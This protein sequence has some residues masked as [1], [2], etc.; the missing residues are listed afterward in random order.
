M[1]SAAQRAFL[2]AALGL[3]GPL[4][5]RAD[6][7][8]NF[9]GLG[10]VQ[11][12]SIRITGH[13]NHELAWLARADAPVGDFY[14]LLY[15]DRA[16]IETHYPL[17]AT[18]RD[19]V[20]W[21]NR[22]FDAHITRREVYVS[23]KPMMR[24]M[25][26]HIRENGPVSPAD[27]NEA[28]I[29]GGFNTIKASTRALEYLYYEGKLQIA[30]RTAHYHRL[31]DLTE[32]VV[33][34]ALAVKRPR[35]AERDAFFARSALEVLKLATPA[36]WVDRIAHHWLPRGGKAEAR[37][38]LERFLRRQSD[39]DI[40]EMAP[41]LFGLRE[42]KRRVENSRGDSD[43][44]RV[45]APLENLLFHRRRFQE[46]FGIPYKFEAYTPVHARRFYYALP[47]LHRDEIIGLLDAGKRGGDWHIVAIELHKPVSRELLRQA[48]H[49]LAGLAGAE[50]ITTARGL[51]RAIAVS[52]KGKIDD[53]ALYR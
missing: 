20:P 48:I 24:R 43:I 3:S 39:E 28:R 21:L 23:L 52:L 1:D 7:K 15:R 44:V 47:L 25:L 19:W 41:G 16:M 2:L 49:R 4:W 32:R 51:E 34:E 36:Q 18:R 17:F 45:L 29:P 30:G 33:P 5:K 13:R 46:L 53:D 27:F 38:M 31:F 22:G 6:A 10:M 26:A 12:D 40:V 11:I 50:R 35:Q 9:V 37:A 42:D 8:K 14:D